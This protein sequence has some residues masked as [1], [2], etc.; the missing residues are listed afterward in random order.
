[1]QTWR[2]TYTEDNGKTYKKITTEAETY[3]KA[4]IA[5]LLKI[6]M[7]GMITDR[8]RIKQRYRITKAII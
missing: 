4:Y 5:T 1:M 6:A 7:G 8:R 2:F 3:S